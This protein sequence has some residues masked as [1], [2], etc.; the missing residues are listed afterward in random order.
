[1]RQIV[2]KSPPPKKR[3]PSRI[4]NVF[5]PQTSQPNSH[6]QSASILTPW[7]HGGTEHVRL[8]CGG[9]GDICGGSKVLDKG[10]KACGS[11]GGWSMHAVSWPPTALNVVGTFQGISGADHP[12]P[13]HST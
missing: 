1:M 8:T 13:Q 5:C 9:D 4:W 6:L 10:S 12:L 7:S 3:R 11:N 2:M